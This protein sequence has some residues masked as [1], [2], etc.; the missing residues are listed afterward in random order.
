[1]RH[2]PTSRTPILAAEPAECNEA[3]GA[4]EQHDYL[5]LPAC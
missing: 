4:V 3:Q 1:M 5:V 2:Q